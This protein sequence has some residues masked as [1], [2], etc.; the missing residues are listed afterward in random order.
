M[1]LT[2]TSKCMA[3]AL[4]AFLHPL[5]ALIT[6]HDS[7]SGDKE[8]PQKPSQYHTPELKQMTVQ[9]ADICARTP[10]VLLYVGNGVYNPLA[11]KC[12]IWFF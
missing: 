3:H 12:M 5:Q 2:K 7:P 1:F 4:S 10:S 9:Q 11:E 8:W 6:L